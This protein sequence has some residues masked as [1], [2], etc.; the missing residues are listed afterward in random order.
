MAD[1]LRAEVAAAAAA[2]AEAAAREAAAKRDRLA[3]AA[4]KA[5]AAKELTKLLTADARHAPKRQ[6][7]ED[8]ELPDTV[9]SSLESKRMALMASQGTFEVDDKVRANYGASRG[10]AKGWFDGKIVAVHNHGDHCRYDIDFEDG[11]GDKETKVIAKYIELRH[12]GEAEEAGQPVAPSPKKVRAPAASKSPQGSPVKSP[13]AAAPAVASKPTPP[14]K[15]VP[16]SSVPKPQLPPPPPKM[17]PLPPSP[18]PKP[19][20]TAQ[21]EQLERF[22]EGE[23][24]CARAATDP[25]KADLASLSS[26]DAILRYMDRLEPGKH[27][28]DRQK[29]SRGGCS[30]TR[31]KLRTFAE[32]NPSHQAVAHWVATSSWVPP[33]EGSLHAIVV[34]LKT[35]NK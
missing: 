20:P 35:L 13:K 9:R 33:N 30:K 11:S 10:Q 15:A 19:A 32:K 29:D 23:S 7:A 34:L 25:P 28:F 21:P 5:A 2:E 8:M 16:L 14:P 26:I 18:S 12:D 31:K 6:R 1:A 24:A 27:Y 4:R 17:K 3:A 22:L